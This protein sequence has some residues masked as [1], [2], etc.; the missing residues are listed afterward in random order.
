M[1]VKDVKPDSRQFLSPMPGM[2]TIVDSRTS[3]AP[4]HL[5]DTLAR[6]YALEIRAGISITKPVDRQTTEHLTKVT[7]G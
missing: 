3:L 6:G 1:A 4:D 5:V 2:R 7:Y